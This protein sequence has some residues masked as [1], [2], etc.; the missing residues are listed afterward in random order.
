MFVVRRF[1]PLARIRTASGWTIEQAGTPWWD[2][3]ESWEFDRW[4]VPGARIELG[5]PQDFGSGRLTA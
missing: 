2:D 5:S 3:R 1:R 4:M